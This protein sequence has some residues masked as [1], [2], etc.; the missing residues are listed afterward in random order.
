MIAPGSQ[1]STSDPSRA[2]APES[3]AFDSRSL[4]IN[5][6]VCIAPLFWVD[7]VETDQEPNWIKAGGA[8]VSGNPG[9]G[10]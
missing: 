3:K 4:S 2:S 8:T 1:P 6:L 7:L 5:D 9:W 10:N